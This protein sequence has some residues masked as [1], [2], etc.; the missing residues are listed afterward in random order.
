MSGIRCLQILLGD[1]KIGSLFGLDNGY[2]YFRFDEAYAKNPQRPILSIQY[3]GADD[4]DT[5][6]VLLDRH[7]KVNAGT[8]NRLPVFF[9]NLLPE[10][11]L[12]SHLM[13]EAKISPDDELGLLAFCGTDLPGNVVAI[14]EELTEK[15]LGRL[16]TQDLDAYE[17][18]SYQLPTP[19]ATSLSG[20]QPKISLINDSQ[21]RYVMRSKNQSG[22]HF[23]GKLPASNYAGL[24][25]VENLSLALAHAAGVN[26]CKTE[27]LP[28]SA[29]AGNLPF[30]MNDDARQF[31]LVHRFDRDVETPSKRLHMED[32]AQ[33]LGLDPESKYKG[34]YLEIGLVL[35]A[36]S[37]N[38][39][40]DIEQLL[41]RI[42]VNELIGNFD[43]HAKN[44]SLLYA[45][46][47]CSCTLS[48]AYDI[49]A[50]SAYL[51]GQGHGMR[52][53]PQDTQRRLITPSVV[54]S[55]A[56]YWSIPENFIKAILRN[57][58]MLA[59]QN[60][61]AMISSSLISDQQKSMLLQHFNT[62]AHIKKLIKT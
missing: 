41:R 13:S 4:V 12:R 5:T 45:G 19:E 53:L 11:V 14:H 39:M 36:R 7:L 43:A 2:S 21:G 35:L 6:S 22:L 25:E 9:R 33:V 49:V 28:L 54:R 58:V 10:G 44:F 37:A 34:S 17:M 29:I 18:S 32:F 46:D 38:P 62:H 26:T 50:Y 1:L 42:M 48:P 31:L 40:G 51:H 3:L 56:N 55:L 60:W 59:I 23:I 16:L 52:F 27:L 8:D 30:T 24:P 61:P 15:S 20:V 47:G 57:V